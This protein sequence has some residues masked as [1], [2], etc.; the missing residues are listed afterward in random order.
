VC[1]KFHPY[2][3]FC[4]L[5]SKST[6]SQSNLKW[7]SYYTWN[8]VFL[9]KLM[10]TEQDKKFFTFR[11]PVQFSMFVRAQH[12]TLFRASWIQ[13]TPSYPTHLD[14]TEHCCRSRHAVLMNPWQ[15]LSC[16]TNVGTGGSSAEL[17]AALTCQYSETPRITSFWFVCLCVSLKCNR[18]N[19]CWY[20]LL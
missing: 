9:K 18:R 6:A 11:R 14:N 13:A 20:S 15:L 5:S 4:S 3:I 17:L 7:G 10:V 8:I 19:L 16:A 2:K 12:W 1:G